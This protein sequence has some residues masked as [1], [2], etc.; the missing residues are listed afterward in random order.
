MLPLKGL[1]VVDLT[2]F[3]PP[4]TTGR[5]LGEWGADVIRWNHLQRATPAAPIRPSFSA[6]RPATGKTSRRYGQLPQAFLS[7]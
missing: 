3:L 5:V 2:T 6:C 4:P 7:H 1:K